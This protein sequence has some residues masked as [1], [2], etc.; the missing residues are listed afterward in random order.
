MKRKVSKVTVGTRITIPLRDTLEEE[1]NAQ[2]VSFC[3]YLEHLLINR[4]SNTSDNYVNVLKQDLG[5]VQKERIELMDE[6]ESLQETITELQATEVSSTEHQSLLERIEVLESQVE[7][8]EEENELLRSSSDEEKLETTRYEEIDAEE[9]I[10]S[11]L[12]KL[13]FEKATLKSENE[14]LIQENRKLQ[15]FTNQLTT[16][17]DSDAIDFLAEKHPDLSKEEI[18]K[19]ALDC[20]ATNEGK[21]LTVYSFADFLKRDEPFI[22]YQN[23]EV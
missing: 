16:A 11:V 17:W 13:E 21:W 5:L 22:N 12:E 23:S 6:L 18:I 2:D 20:S 10:E 19:T 4:D 7:E 8:L 9:M 1:A 15:H 3:A 14:K